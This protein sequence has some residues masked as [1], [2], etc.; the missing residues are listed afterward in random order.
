MSCVA[1]GNTPATPGPRT[2]IPPTLS[3]G[4]SSR[5]ALLRTWTGTESE[6]LTL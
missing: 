6:A 3:T 5:L 2:T 1:V 4:G